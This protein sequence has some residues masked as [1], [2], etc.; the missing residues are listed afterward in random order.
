VSEDCLSRRADRAERA[1]Y[2]MGWDRKEEKE[3]KKNGLW[4][5]YDFLSFF[6]SE[7]IPFRKL[8]W[9]DM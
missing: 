1:K 4:F 8:K 2:G 9:H 3:R 7:F 5:G 6:L